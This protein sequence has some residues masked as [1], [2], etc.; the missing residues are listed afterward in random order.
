MFQSKCFKK[1]NSL[2]KGRQILH[3]SRKFC[4][5]DLASVL[6]EVLEKVKEYR[7]LYMVDEVKHQ[8]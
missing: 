5:Q 4:C 2:K 6:Q 7:Y 1:P 3:D 8:P